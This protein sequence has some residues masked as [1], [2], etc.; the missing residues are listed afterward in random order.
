MEKREPSCT[1]GGNVNWSSHC[2]RQYGVSSKKLKV[3]L[4]YDPAILLL[5]I[6]MNKAITQKKK[7]KKTKPKNK[8]YLCVCVCVCVCV[9]LC[10]CV[11]VLSCIWLCATPWTISHQVPLSM[12]FSRWEYWNGLPFPT[13]VGIFL[14]WGSN[15]RLLHLLL[16]Q[17][18]SSPLTP[19]GKPIPV[20]SS[21]IYNSQDIETTQMSRKREMDNEDVID[22]HNG[23][24]CACSVAQSCL[25]ICDPMDC[26]S[27]RLLCPWDFPGKNIG[28]GCHFLLQGS[29]PPRD[30]THVSA[31][32]ALAG[33]FFTTEPSGKPEM[34][35]EDA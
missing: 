33:R 12:G 9:C 26:S 24:L 31:A 30:R 14:A 3:E 32:P 27:P 23:I 5:G 2:G 21:T 34:D 16:W 28:V 8:M 17:S 25:T 35:K 10:V 29:S 19:P 13:P 22:K 20:F 15:L 6:Y 4:S 7:K 11:C 18:N 1:V